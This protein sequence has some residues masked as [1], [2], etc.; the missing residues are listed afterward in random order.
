MRLVYID[1]CM[2][3]RRGKQVELLRGERPER[4]VAR[5]IIRWSKTF[6]LSLFSAG[7][8]LGFGKVFEV[9]ISCESII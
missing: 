5:T 9:D 2:C 8:L 4:K 6:F 1:M 3:V 7:E